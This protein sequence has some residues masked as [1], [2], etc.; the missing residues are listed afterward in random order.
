MRP[1]DTSQKDARREYST[2]HI[3][4]HFSLAS[5][6]SNDEIG[7]DVSGPIMSKD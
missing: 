6:Q 1:S 7:E 3:E 2:E 5:S 4:F